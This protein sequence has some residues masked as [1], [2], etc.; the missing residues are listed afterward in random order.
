MPYYGVLSLGLI[1]TTQWATLPL[2][3][4]P[5]QGQIP[6]TISAGAFVLLLLPL[7]SKYFVNLICSYI[8]VSSA[9]CYKYPLSICTATQLTALPRV[10]TAY[11]HICIRPKFIGFWFWFW[12][13]TMKKAVL[14]MSKYDTTLR[15]LMSTWIMFWDNSGHKG[16]ELSNC[17]KRNNY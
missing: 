4:F 14:K 17:I 1:W 10:F 6:Q 11:T 2:P 13:E 7:S 9:N 5:L 8:C 3:P 12:Y 15:K 16:P